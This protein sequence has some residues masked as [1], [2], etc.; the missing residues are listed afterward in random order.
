MAKIVQLPK[1]LVAIKVS[2]F[3]A[4][5]LVLITKNIGA[6]LVIFCDGGVD[7]WCWW[8]Q[9]TKSLILFYFKSRGTDKECWDGNKLRKL[10]WASRIISVFNL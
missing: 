10:A 4:Y 2:I 1:T 3:V 5:K 8:Q 6:Q 7:R 9:G